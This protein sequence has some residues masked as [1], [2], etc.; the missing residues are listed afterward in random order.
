MASIYRL[1]KLRKAQRVKV[2]SDMRKFEVQMPN[3]LW[4]STA[5]TGPKSCTRVECERPICSPSS[6]T[7]PG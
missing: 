6:M 5:C 1:M 4:Q 2:A 7:T 3:D